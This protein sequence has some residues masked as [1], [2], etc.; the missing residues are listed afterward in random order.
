MELFETLQDYLEEETNLESYLIYESRWTGPPA[1]RKDPFTLDEVDI[2]FMAS[3]DFLGMVRER[4][5]YV[6]LCGAGAVFGHSKNLKNR[7]HYYTDVIIPA[8]TK[9]KYKELHDLRGHSLAFSSQKSV[10]SAMI[11]LGTLK[12]MGFNSSFFSNLQETGSHLASIQ[13]VLDNRVT[14]AAVDSNVLFN[15]LAKIPGQKEHLQLFTSFG[16]LPTYPIVFNSRLPAELKTK[17]TDSL[18]KMSKKISWCKRI[19]QFNISEFVPIDMSLYDIEKDLAEAVHGMS[20][21]STYY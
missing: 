17:I 3:S 21:S 14:A 1:G 7:P 6:E 12:K 10:S 5:Q 8:G 4:N 11:V 2:G 18:I 16:P 9:S 20:L 13:S 15:Y 19:Q